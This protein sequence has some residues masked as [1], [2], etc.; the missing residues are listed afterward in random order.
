MKKRLID[1][2]ALSG[3]A[4]GIQFYG[5]DQQ[6]KLRDAISKAARHL[7]GTNA[8]TNG[9]SITQISGIRPLLT[10]AKVR[11]KNQI[12]KINN[13][14]DTRLS[15][16]TL[17]RVRGIQSLYHRTN[18]T[19]ANQADI[20]I[21]CQTDRNKIVRRLHQNQ[22]P[23]LEV[24][25]WGSKKE[26]ESC[27][28][29][30]KVRISED[31]FC[32]HR[33][34]LKDNAWACCPLCPDPRNPSERPE[35]SQH[36]CYT[37]CIATADKLEGLLTNIER[38]DGSFHRP[39]NK[40]DLFTRILTPEHW[41]KNAN[42]KINKW[43]KDINDTVN[44]ALIANHMPELAKIINTQDNIPLNENVEG[45]VFVVNNDKNSGVWAGRRRFRATNYCHR[46]NT[47]DGDT[48]GLDICD[49]SQDWMVMPDMDLND[50]LK[51]GRLTFITEEKTVWLDKDIE[52]I[53]QG[54]LF[55]TNIIGKTLNIRRQQNSQ[56][57]TSITV[58]KYD[59][60]TDRHTVLDCTSST[61]KLLRLPLND[62][63]AKG[64]IDPSSLAF[65]SEVLSRLR[66]RITPSPSSAARS[67]PRGMID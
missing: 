63:R 46:T 14:P 31:A 40:A 64:W 3:I 16:I 58:M 19:P 25:P 11:A 42:I 55:D 18:D 61:P 23:H 5:W 6:K 45:Q 38:D 67:M 33:N 10:T 51:A 39:H 22:R 44:S 48:T 53:R 15:K 7:T 17:N 66:V 2:T 60:R 37:D 50:Y 47:F 36:H 56:S 62:M 1:A 4:Y 35:V 26:A 52:R 27:G 32:I 34:K 29:R 24:G 59:K 12:N 49:E 21:M 41:S 28:I 57:Y 9:E 30:N 8:R 13:L 20:N 65:F 54:L 43:I